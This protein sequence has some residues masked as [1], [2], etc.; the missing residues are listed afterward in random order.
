MKRTDIIKLKELINRGWEINEEEGTIKN[1]KTGRNIKI[2]TAL[3]YDKEHPAYKAALKAQG[4]N[5]TGS[6]DGGGEG[7]K[8]IK[9]ISK[10][11]D[12]I[13]KN[14]LQDT[15]SQGGY[16]GNLDKE[17]T[18]KYFSKLNDNEKKEFIN[19]LDYV[20]KT[21]IKLRDAEGQE[22]DENYS[23]IVDSKDEVYDKIVSKLEDDGNFELVMDLEKVYRALKDPSYSNG[24][25]DSV[26]NYYRLTQDHPELKIF[27]DDEF[28]TV[29]DSAKKID[30]L[31]DKG[32][33]LVQ[34]IAPSTYDAQR[35]LPSLVDSLKKELGENPN[36]SINYKLKKLQEALTQV[37]KYQMDEP[38][39][40][41]EMAKSQMLK[42][43]KYAADIMNMIDDSS[44]LPAWV[45]S[46]LTKIADYIGAVKHYMDSKTVRHVVTNMGE[47]VERKS[48]EI[49]LVDMVPVNSR[50][51]SVN[52]V[53][54]RLNKKVKSYLD[55]YLKSEK[56]N[57]PEH[58]HTIML[59]MKGA[60]TDAN[61]HSEARQ[62]DKFFPKAKQSEYVGT[63]ME[64]VIED[65]GTDIAGWA[66]WDGHDII[67]A[68]AFYT[69]MTIGGGFGNKLTALKESVNEGKKDYKKIFTS[70]ENFKKDLKKKGYSRNE[71]N[72]TL[73]ADFGSGDPKIVQ[74]IKE[75][76]NEAS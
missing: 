31:E 41:G 39:H 76:V 58:Q 22:Y 18:I 19:T 35:Y 16:A 14:R 10:V 49:R 11:S 71:I 12:A 29:L 33:A 68:F 69:N 36:E 26:E 7:S 53:N 3:G 6:E 27:S 45:Q 70:I 32:D 66:K 63:E 13:Q 44:N 60:L 72:A 34:G 15:T 73:F 64:D 56:K 40:E 62:L 1:P 17:A 67:D 51:E 59:I 5:D 55:A 50:R 9:Q 48:E 4:S 57:S 74:K 75:S 43:M 65:K 54:A 46:K 23:P 21:S 2:S 42:T 38:D 47:G 37:Q 30:K 61:F 28:K 24:T 8:L 20:A 25:L 52:E